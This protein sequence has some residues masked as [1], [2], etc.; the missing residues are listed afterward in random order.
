MGTSTTDDPATGTTTPLADA[1]PPV[2]PRRAVGVARRTSAAPSP[3]RF[4]TTPRYPA[5][6]HVAGGRLVWDGARM[7]LVRGDG[8][9]LEPAGVPVVTITGD[10]PTVVVT[11]RDDHH[12]TR[13]VL[14]DGSSAR[15]ARFARAL[16]AARPGSVVVDDRTVPSP[17]VPRLRPGQPGTERRPGVFAR[18]LW[19]VVGRGPA[20]ASTAA[21]G[22]LVAQLERL[23]AL[24]RAGDLDAAEF[25]RAKARLLG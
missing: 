25:A 21:G 18:A 15:F 11:W 20:T 24:H 9:V 14:L 6:F 4:T 22:D 10:G 17:R 7:R 23:A 1:P 5:M 2:P 8:A 3:A 13:T 12:A 16:H 19:R